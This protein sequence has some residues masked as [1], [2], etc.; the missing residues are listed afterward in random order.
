MIVDTDAVVS[1]LSTALSSALPAGFVI[2]LIERAVG[3][4]YDAV[5]GRKTR[6]W[7]D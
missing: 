2:A 4:F 6:N 1:L 5:T 7:G 3:L